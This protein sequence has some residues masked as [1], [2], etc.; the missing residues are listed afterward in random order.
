TVL[1]G[2]VAQPASLVTD[3]LVVQVFERVAPFE[4]QD[5]FDVDPADLRDPLDEGHQVCVREQVG[6]DGVGAVRLAA[7]EWRDDLADLGWHLSGHQAPSRGSSGQPGA[8]DP[9]RFGRERSPSW[10]L[11][12]YAAA[13]ARRSGDSPRSPIPRLH[14]SQMSPR[15]QEPQDQRPGQQAWSWS[16]ANGRR[17]SVCNTPQMAQAP[18]CALSRA[19]Y[20]SG[21]MP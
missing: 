20:C 10:R 18:L 1:A 2:V 4:V 19:S 12:R 5:L 9:A 8:G 16:T 21:V 17:L 6:G 7:K 11:S 15:M 14:L 13:A 3:R